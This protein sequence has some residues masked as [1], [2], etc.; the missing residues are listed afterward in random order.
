[1]PF[2]GVSKQPQPRSDMKLEERKR[3]GEYAVGGGHRGLYSERCWVAVDL[4]R[5]SF[6]CFHAGVGFDARTHSLHAK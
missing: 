4:P 1:M 6:R 5:S 2:E 3:Q